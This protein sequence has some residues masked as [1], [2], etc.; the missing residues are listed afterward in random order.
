M[1]KEK[2]ML[3]SLKESKA[4][5]LAQVITNDSCRKILDYLSEK[6]DSTESVMADELKLPISTV[7]YNLQLLIKSGIVVS[8]EYHYS[9]KGKEVNHYQLA[10]KYII[11]APKSIHGIKEKLRSIL[12]AG[13]IAAAGAGLLHW[14]STYY[15]A[16]AKILAAAPLM[17]SAKGAASAPFV[18]SVRDEAVQAITPSIV[19]KSARAAIEKA[20]EAVVNVTTS[21][22][23][24]ALW[25]LIG[26]VFVIVLLVFIEM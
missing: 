15:S 20:P 4:K 6:E 1:G 22:T 26:A 2:F 12:P 14:Y 11:I 3:V 19:E 21:D 25:F 7:H 24:I 13:L 5:E 18:E 23:S 9:A 10:N 17:Q 8:E 16:S